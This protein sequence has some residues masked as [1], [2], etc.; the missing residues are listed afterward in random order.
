MTGGGGVD[1]LDL[2][3]LSALTKSPRSGVLELSRRVGVARATAQARLQRLEESGVITGYGPEIDLGAAGF[4]VQAFVTLE[5]AQGA[6]DDVTADL[7]AIPGVLEA[8]ATTGAG[9]VL[10]RVAAESH[11]ALQEILLRLGRSSCVVRSTS[12]IVLSELVPRRAL[13]LLAA[14]G[15]RPAGRAPAYRSGTAGAAR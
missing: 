5:I 2:A 7:A 14:G 6:L 11:G 1:A 9:D 10:C 13:P 12:V 8:H 3:L 15:A 4:A